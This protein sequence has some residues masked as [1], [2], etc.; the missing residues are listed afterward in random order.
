MALENWLSALNAM[1]NPKPPE[2]CPAGGGGGQGEEGESKTS[3]G[4]EGISE[5]LRNI[6]QMGEDEKEFEPAKKGSEKETLKPW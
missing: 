1:D 6:I 4:S 3:L 2:T 5:V